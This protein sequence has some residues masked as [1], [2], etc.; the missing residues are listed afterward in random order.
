MR[1]LFQHKLG[2]CSTQ[3]GAHILYGQNM[4]IISIG[5]MNRTFVYT[6]LK[7]YTIIIYI[8]M[9]NIY[10]YIEWKSFELLFENE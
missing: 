7:K 6:L 2:S 5:L 3:D 10:S 4:R 1:E 9:Y 8:N